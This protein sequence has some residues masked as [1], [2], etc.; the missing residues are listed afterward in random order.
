MRCLK[1]LLINSTM[2]S[3]ISSRPFFVF[4]FFFSFT[5]LC[6]VI[7]KATIMIYKEEM[8]MALNTLTEQKIHICREIRDHLFNKIGF[9]LISRG[10]F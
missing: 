4:F 7:K 6:Q 9:V 3:S 10:Q 2:E 5:R 1:P 8:T